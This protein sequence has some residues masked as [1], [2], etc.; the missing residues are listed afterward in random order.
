MPQAPARMAP[1][2]RRAQIIDGAAEVAWAQGLAN[3]TLRRVATQANITYGLVNH[4][5]PAVNDLVAEAFSVL[6]TRDRQDA[7]RDCSTGGTALG[8]LRLLL[9]R[10]VRPDSDRM[11]LLWL[12]AWSLA[13][14]NPALRQAIDQRMG[15]GHRLVS[16]ILTA[17]IQ[18]GTFRPHDPEAVAWTLLTLLDGLIVHSS[19]QINAPRIDVT[20]T[21]RNLLEDQLGLSRGDLTIQ[22]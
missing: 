3:V 20:A 9:A 7:E 19:L 12:D 16:G 14:E 13:A 1:A 17:G 6:A 18:E 22:A 8:Q 2:Q 11:G 15:D 10:W 5:F 4:Y 21:V